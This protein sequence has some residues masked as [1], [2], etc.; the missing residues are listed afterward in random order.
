MKF[1]NRTTESIL[2]II[3]SLQGTALRLVENY[4]FSKIDG[5]SAFDDLMKTLD[6]A[7]R[8]DARVRLPQDF[9]G[10]F[11][12]LPRKPGQALLSFITN[13]DE[14]LQKCWGTWHEIPDEVQGWLLLKTA[15][16]TREQRQKN[17]VSK[18]PDST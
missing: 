17:C 4:D 14:K 18:G 3:G 2:I 7:L 11:T 9:D 12:H 1:Q 15:N 8:C 16:V 13:H 6:T 10:Y 5:E